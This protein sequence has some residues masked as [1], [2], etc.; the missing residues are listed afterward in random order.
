LSDSSSAFQGRGPSTVLLLNVLAHREAAQ[1]VRID[2]RTQN[3]LF[4]AKPIAVNEKQ[5]FR[6]IFIKKVFVRSVSGT[7]EKAEPPR[8]RCRG[9]SNRPDQSSKKPRYLHDRSSKNHALSAC[10]RIKN[11]L[12]A[13]PNSKNAL[14]ARPNSKNALSARPKSNHPR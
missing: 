9:G 4:I 1:D 10:P 6:D 8:H 3:P 11:A 5:P 14:S 7:N 12:S 2:S 13:R